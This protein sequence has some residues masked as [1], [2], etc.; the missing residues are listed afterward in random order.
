MFSA[1]DHSFTQPYDKRIEL[2]FDDLCKIDITNQNGKIGLMVSQKYFLMKYVNSINNFEEMDQ[3]TL[4]VY[5]SSDILY[6][7]MISLP[8]KSLKTFFL[9]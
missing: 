7:M 6:P 4:N 2:H 9:T 3:G 5:V 8:H 1:S